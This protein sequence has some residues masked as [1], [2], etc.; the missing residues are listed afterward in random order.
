MHCKQNGHGRTQ[1]CSQSDYHGNKGRAANE[2]AFLHGGNDMRAG[3][4]QHADH[5][6]GLGGPE[7][8]GMQIAVNPDRL[9]DAAA[10]STG[11]VNEVPA[12]I[13]ALLGFAGLVD[14]S[15]MAA[16]FRITA[17][18][19]INNGITEEVE[20]TQKDQPNANPVTCAPLQNRNHSMNNY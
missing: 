12:D 17:Q 19:G 16:V 8:D 9:G 3:K 4:D 15:P 1:D 10:F 6:D 20:Q 7:R 5:H 13:I 11:A 14:V 18:L 2:I